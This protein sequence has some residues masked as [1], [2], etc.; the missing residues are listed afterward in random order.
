ME[1][2]E[3]IVNVG[4]QGTFRPSGS[5]HTKP[6]DID[7]IFQNYKDQNVKNISLYFHGGLV[8]E[9]TGM[10]TAEK[11]AKHIVQAGQSPLC[12]VWETGL[13][14]TVKSNI[15]KISETKLFNKLVKVL[16]K[17]LSQ[18]LG[19][20]LADGRGISNMLSDEEIDLELT[21]PDPFE[22]Y[23]RKKLDES[24]RGEE[25]ITMLPK[26]ENVLL[27]E[28]E[29][30][31]TYMIQADFDFEKTI[32]ETEL[33]I[34]SGQ[35]ANARGFISTAAIIKHVAL[36]A[37]KVIKRFI[38]KRDHDLYPTIIEEILRELYVAE[39]GAW[40]WN[41]MKNKSS[42]MWDDNNGNSGLNQYA[43]RYLLE[44]LSNY[45]K[46][47]NA[48]VN[49]IGH[50]AGSIA[51]CNLLNVTARIYPE[52][53]YNKVLFLAPACRIES[54]YKEFVSKES[55]F[56]WF[57]MF[58]MNDQFETKDRLVPYLYTHSLLYLI[59]G[60]LEEEGQEFDSYILGLERHINGKHPYDNIPE[61]IKTHDFLYKQDLNRVVFSQTKT[62]APQGLATRSTT[63]G[64]FDDD[65]FTIESIKHILKDQ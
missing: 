35:K 52:L 11:M 47:N 44:K 9:K 37:F 43:G 27:G 7:E 22:S 32:N 53:I 12:I 54:F 42:E 41:G 59:S 36:I 28:L 63:H 48:E 23:S 56:K 1:A 13:L 40:V 38:S 31:F 6:E 15:G 4:P 2:K 64:D 30:E 34:P 51:I 21:K 46:E 17:K 20:D 8:N 24:G 45:V 19:F 39:V 14:E 62:T 55:R 18:K 5:Y 10:D 25:A 26:N 33:F 61:L 50:S 29:L 49:L 3:Y 57:R 65:K 16:V 58:T 60:I